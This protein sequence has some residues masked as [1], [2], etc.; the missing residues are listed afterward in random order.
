MADDGPCLRGISVGEFSDPEVDLR[1][2]SVVSL[3]P[4]SVRRSSIRYELR[5]GFGGDEWLP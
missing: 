2:H 5:L 4:S 3:S 1:P